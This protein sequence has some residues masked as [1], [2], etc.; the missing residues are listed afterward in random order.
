MKLILLLMLGFTTSFAQKKYVE[1]AIN[2]KNKRGDFWLVSI[3]DSKT[4]DDKDI[5]ELCEKNNYYCI[6]YQYRRVNEFGVKKEVISSF[7]FMPYADKLKLDEIKSISSTESCNNALSTYPHERIRI[8]KTYYE[9][10]RNNKSLVSFVSFRGIFMNSEYIPEL[11]KLV[12]NNILKQNIKKE[13][14]FE[15]LATIPVFHGKKFNIDIANENQVKNLLD[16]IESKSGSFLGSEINRSVKFRILD[17]VPLFQTTNYDDYAKYALDQILYERSVEYLNNYINRFPKSMYVKEAKDKITELDNIA[18]KNA[19][20][21]NT[22]ESYLDYQ[23][24]FP[25]G[26]NFS[27]AVSGKIAILNEI[28]RQELVDIEN[29]RREEENIRNREIYRQNKIKESSIGDRLC[30]VQGWLNKD[31]GIFGFF[32]STTK[33]SMVIICF[34]ENINKDN[35]QIRVGD[36]SSTNSNYYGQPEINGIKYSKGDI[37]WIKPLKDTNWNLC[38]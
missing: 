20:E 26:I 2:N 31:P 33:Y 30:Y 16:E 13:N 22:L 6:D 24:K 19:E 3:P 1:E 4:Y 12:A 5:T 9:F 29:K 18:Y 17:D 8:E 34:I 21:I 32:S 23:K 14:L 7:K 28:R 15:D 37:I 11:E 10:C 38:E 25:K 35:Y 27:K 36:V